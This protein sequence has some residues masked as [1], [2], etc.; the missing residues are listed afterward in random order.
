MKLRGNYEVIEAET[1]ASM[2]KHNSTRSKYS[3][4]VNFLLCLLFLGVL[5][6]AITNPTITKLPATYAKTV[7]NDMVETK[8]SNMNSLDTVTVNQSSSENSIQ[9]D[10]QPLEIIQTDLEIIPTDDDRVD[11]E[12]VSNLPT[13]ESVMKV[14]QEQNIPTEQSEV[15]DLDDSN[16]INSDEITEINVALDENEDDKYASVDNVIDGQIIHTKDVIGELTGNEVTYKYELTEEERSILERVV[17]AEVASSFVYKGREVSE[18][19]ILKSKIRVAQVFYNRVKDEKKFSSIAN[20][21]ESLLLP[22][23]TST[24][25]NGSYYKVKVT[26]LT[27][28]AV[29]LAFRDSTEDYT[30]GALFFHSGTDVSSPYGTFLFTDSVGHKFFK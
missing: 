10:E 19:E 18:D 9:K 25:G 26:D 29:E 27:K 8:E 24:I 4:N 5:A 2:K 3:S 28:E 15:D 11:I 6:I 23:A 14:I 20:M 16:E 1:K 12:L 17:E 22:G 13:E 30:N 21:K 7:V